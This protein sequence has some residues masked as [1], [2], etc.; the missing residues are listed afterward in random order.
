MKIMAT[1]LVFFNMRYVFIRI[2]YRFGM[3]ALLTSAIV[4]RR[5]ILVAIDEL[6]LNTKE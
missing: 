5:L 4:R 1:S 3:K 2:S 6:H